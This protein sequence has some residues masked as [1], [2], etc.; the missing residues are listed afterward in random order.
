MNGNGKVVKN[1]LIYTVSNILLKAFSFF[2]LP[3]YTNFLSTEEYGIVSIVNGFSSV[4][5]YLIVFSLYSAVFRFYAD[6]KEDKLSVQRYLGT[7]YTFCLL[8]N[9]VFIAICL[10]CKNIIS[11]F[12]FS[13]IKFYPIVVLAIVNTSAHSMYVLYQDT[14]KSMQLAKKSAITS[15]LFFFV[16]LCLCI[17]MVIVKKTGAVGTVF[18]YATANVLFCVGSLV[19]LRRMQVIRWGIDWKILRDSLKYS[20]PLLPHN[21]STTIAQYV[22]KLV[23]SDYHSFS[24]LGVFNLALQFGLIADVVQSSVS[25]AFQPWIYDQLNERSEKTKKNIT[26]LTIMLTWVYCIVFLLIGLFSKEAIILIAN[27]SYIDAWK[28]V[29]LIIVTYAIKVPYYFYVTVL[30]YYK[31]AANKIF[32]ITVSTSIINVVMSVALIPRM[33]MYG[34]ILADAV[35]MFLRVVFVVVFSIRYGNVGFNLKG[36][37]L[38]IA[39]TIG[40]MGLFMMPSY[41][42]YTTSLIGDI[43]FKVCGVLIY[44]MSILIL[45]RR[46]MNAMK[47]LINSTLEKIFKGR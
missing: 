19:D 38:R 5:I 42:G 14:L 41:L 15:V 27:Q 20:L 29:P 32:I 12:F 35:S 17:W 43:L 37:V 8:T 46:K 36:I 9:A 3:I 24:T 2:L 16:Q 45:E 11:M 13:G 28:I 10:L 44:I 6:I 26:S 25:S 33:G 34:S 22:S 4:A 1:S 7:V 23:V 30:F 21:L 31:N 18:A 39:Y 47:V 40:V